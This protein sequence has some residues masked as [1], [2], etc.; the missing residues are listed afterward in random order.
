VWMRAAEEDRFVED[1]VDDDRPIANAWGQAF[2]KGGDNVT[3]EAIPKG[4]NWL[5]A[6]QEP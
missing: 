6:W 2:P 1:H 3:A 4:R 5:G